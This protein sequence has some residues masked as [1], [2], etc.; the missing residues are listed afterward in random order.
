MELNFKVLKNIE[1]KIG[2]S[3]YI[4]DIEKFEQNYQNFLAVFRSIYPS[5]KI[6]YSY[7]TNYIPIICKTVN[8]NGGYAEVVSEMEYDLA[9]QVGV[10]FQNIIVNGPVKPKRALEKFFLNGSIVNL[11][12][13][14][15]A[16]Y[17]KYLAKKHTDKLFYTGLRCNFEFSGL[18]ISRFGLDVEAPAFIELIAEL[19]KINNVKL[20]CLHCHFP[21]RELELFNERVEKMIDLYKKYYKDGQPFFIDLGGGLGGN[22]D[23]FI[24]EQLNYDVANYQDYANIIAT[25]FRNE[26][27]NSK[28]K[29]VLILEPGT[30][31][32]ADTMKYV[33]KVLEIKKI[34]DKY[35]AITSGSKVNFH[36]LSSKINLPVKVF[37]KNNENEIFYNSIDMSGYTC[38]ENDYLFRNYSG[39]VKVGD[40]LVLDN[41]GSY[42]I[43]FKPPFILPNFP[44]ITIK[45]EMIDIVKRAETFEDIF[46]TYI[47][48]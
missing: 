19:Q 44:I 5:T 22:L 38:M 21:N 29:P 45:N 27:L 42:S 31:L 2:D 36:P 25:K 43:V 39:S 11:D 35:I 4:L 46:Q 3:F 47:I 14:T 37:C 40:F 15:E 32:V 8:K 12:S 9:I 34:R 1:N 20:I 17:L 41:V 23:E 6:A 26:F 24:K 30:A 33:C 7:K 16:N 48:N 28:T 10:E 13:Y 18:N